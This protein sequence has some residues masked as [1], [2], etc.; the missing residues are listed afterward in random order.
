[1]SLLENLR[2]GT[3]STS[4]RVLIGVVA[5]VFIFWGVG[6]NSNDKTSIYAEVNGIAI[7]DSEFRRGFAIQARMRGGNLSE[8]EEKALG[9]EVLQGLIE[10]EALYQEARRLGIEVSDEEVA[11]EVVKQDA[12]KKDGKFDERTYQKV[13]KSNQLSRGLFEANLRRDLTLQKLREVVALGV[14]VT[15][16]ELKRAYVERETQVDVDFVRF[17]TPAF[18][19]DVTIPDA[20]RDAFVQQ[21]GDK[22]KARYDELYDR[23]YNLPKRFQLRSI[24]LRTDLEGTDKE[25]VRRRAEQARAEA[26]GGADFAQLAMRW[27]EDLTASSGG[28]LGL[29]AV[30]QIDPALV[31]AAEKAGPGKVTE[32]VETGRGFQVVLVE[33]IEDA[34]LISFD[35]AKPEIA[36][37]MLREERAPAVMNAYAQ[38]VLDAW[39]ASG[40]P[41]TDLLAAQTLE[42][43]QTGPFSS[44]EAAVPR[45]GDDATL[46]AAIATAP[47]GTVIP[48]LFS[49]K[50]IPVIAAVRERT[51]ADMA[52]FSMMEPMMRAQL[53]AMRQ[54]E[55]YEAWVQDVKSRAKI[56]NNLKL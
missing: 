47:P 6:N 12:F 31:T 34:R 4:T 45:L 18:L 37:T 50:G 26:A 38:K 41:P 11:R 1:M 7:T 20:D 52:R 13:L 35:E 24:L 9:A 23:F 28:N 16:A 44:A 15:D 49:V 29:Q 33:K 25:E 39:K 42:V 19:D 53:T 51:E 8:E 43:E 22:L 40:A 2:K 46:R 32:V 21:N 54:Q 5:A 55:L 3:D 27:S 56:E 36:V 48:Q 14:S 10:Q 17:P 30:S